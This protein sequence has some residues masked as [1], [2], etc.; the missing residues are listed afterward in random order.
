MLETR[1]KESVKT[2]MLEIIEDHRRKSKIFVQKCNLG[3]RLFLLARLWVFANLGPGL[4]VLVPPKPPLEYI[5]IVVVVVI[6]VVVAD[7][8]MTW[9]MQ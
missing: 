8:A 7:V 5:E 1:H 9:T 4:R 2:K 6:V 3:F